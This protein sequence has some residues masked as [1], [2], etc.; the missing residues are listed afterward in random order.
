MKQ[1]RETRVSGF[2][3]RSVIELVSV[4]LVQELLDL[5]SE[6]LAVAVCIQFWQL[7]V[8]LQEH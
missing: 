1:C 3:L 6:Y 7:A 8:N 2:G 5:F 4:L